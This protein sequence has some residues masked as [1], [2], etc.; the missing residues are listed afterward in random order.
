MTL[1]ERSGS[2]TICITLA[3]SAIADINEPIPKNHNLLLTISQLSYEET[4]YSVGIQA[5]YA[6]LRRQVIKSLKTSAC[7]RLPS[8]IENEHACS[9]SIRR[10][11]T[12]FLAE[13]PQY[14]NRRYRPLRRTPQRPKPNHTRLNSN[15]AGK[16]CKLQQFRRKEMPAGMCLRYFEDDQCCRLSCHY[17]PVPLARFLFSSS[18]SQTF[19]SRPYL[20]CLCKM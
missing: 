4:P 9:F 10:N 18:S 11:L 8:T 5:P 14:C 13:T 7:T 17:H 2:K 15:S 16:V 19:P 1:L 6:N 3:R 12:L 20:P